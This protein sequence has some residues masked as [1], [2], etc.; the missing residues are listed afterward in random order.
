M[1]IKSFTIIVLSF[2]FI[3]YACTELET[4]E[5]REVLQ[6]SEKYVESRVAISGTLGEAFSD[7]EYEYLTRG[8]K[9][10]FIR[11][12]E[13]YAFPIKIY[14]EP[15]R[16]FYIGRRYI[17]GGVLRSIEICDCQRKRDYANGISYGW[18]KDKATILK[19]CENQPS[20]ESESIIGKV[21][22]SYRCKPDS[23]SRYYYLEATERLKLL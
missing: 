16:E 13:G 5:I 8:Q 7:V 23:K 21:V 11:D 22:V 18:E 10:Y 6:N 19:N 14:S 15:N 3:L 12:E 2:A 1:R 4:N 9:L 20:Q 17:V